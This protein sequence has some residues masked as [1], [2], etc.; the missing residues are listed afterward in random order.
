MNSLGSELLFFPPRV[1]LMFKIN[2]AYNAMTEGSRANLDV[3]NTSLFF[4]K[5][6]ITEIWRTCLCYSFTK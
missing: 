1:H 5:N 3:L 6:T 2:L 4:S